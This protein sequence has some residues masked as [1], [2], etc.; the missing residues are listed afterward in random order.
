MRRH[1]LILNAVSVLSNHLHI[2]AV[3]ESA[4]Q[5]ADFMRDFK[6]KLAREVNRL[7]GWSGPVFERRYEMTV[8]TQ[9]DRPQIERLSYVLAQSV[10]EDL[11]EEVREWPGVHSAAALIDG[12]PLAGHWFDRTREYAAY[13]ERIKGLVEGIESD[14][15]LLRSLNGTSVL[16]V[17][18]I[19]AKDPQHRPESIARSPAPLVHAAT[20]AARKAFYDAYAWFVAA[21]RQA[22]E[23]LRQGDRNAVFPAGS[24]PPALPFV[25]G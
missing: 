16:G 11:V 17:E 1:N 4:R 23:K 12:T 13:R 2:L 24:F 9:E 18:A 20:K 25:A 10:K 6:S 14:A 21:F 22:A 15:A 3:P 8:V 19:L 7:T 5:L